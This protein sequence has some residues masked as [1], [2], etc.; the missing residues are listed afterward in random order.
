MGQRSRRGRSYWTA[1]QVIRGVRIANL[2]AAFS[3]PVKSL[4]RQ[5]G[6]LFVRK[7]DDDPL[8]FSSIFALDVRVEVV[9]HLVDFLELR[10][11]HV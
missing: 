6:H 9:E 2:D 10:M 4:A 11:Q 8:N 7:R 5:T 3:S 1:S